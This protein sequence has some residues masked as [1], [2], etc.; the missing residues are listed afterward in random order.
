MATAVLDRTDTTI[1]T[2]TITGMQRDLEKLLT[3]ADGIDLRKLRGS[4]RD[5]VR[6][7]RTLLKQTMARVN[8]LATPNQG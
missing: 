2:R 1:D 5:T 6:E 8:M 3:R 4:Q 7:V